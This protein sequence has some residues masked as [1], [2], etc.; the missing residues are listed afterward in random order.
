MDGFVGKQTAWLV[1]LVG[2]VRSARSARQGARMTKT[3]RITSIIAALVGGVLLIFPVAFGVRS[4]EAAE[5]FLSKAGAIEEF[6]EAE[7]NKPKT[8]RSQTSP[9]VKQAE[10]FALY[11]DP[12]AKMQPRT[13]RPTTSITRPRP[14]QSSA[15]FDLISTCYNTSR[16]EASLA[17]VREP[18]GETRW[19]K[20]GSELGHTKVEKIEDGFIVLH[21]GQKTSQMPVVARAQEGSLLEGSARP[22]SSV[23]TGPTGPVPR[24]ALQAPPTPGP[25]TAPTRRAAPPKSAEDKAALEDLVGKLKT[26]QKTFRSDKTDSGVSPQEK[27]AM[28]EKL[29]SDYK[30]MR[31]GRDEADKLGDLGRKLNRTTTKNSRPPGPSGRERSSNRGRSLPPKPPK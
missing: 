29:I 30:S 11:L 18:D 6:K 20:Q 16:P 31:M 5:Q 2:R 27:A 26:L 17:F 10:A 8:T 12:P 14:V 21:D 28:M 4:D 24:P 22:A 9:L 25:R 23:P 1:Y 19:V 15:K 13:V 3:L 7:G